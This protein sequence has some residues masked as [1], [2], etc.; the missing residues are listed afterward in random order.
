VAA[1]TL[2]L[3]SIPTDWI[4]LNFKT[5]ESEYKIVPV[6]APLP[7]K[8]YHMSYPIKISVIKIWFPQFITL[9]DAFLTYVW[10]LTAL[11]ISH[12]NADHERWKIKTLLYILKIT[13]H[14]KLE[15]HSL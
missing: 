13:H 9:Y 15:D 4:V 6:S 8:K 11:M 12:S 10:V 7:H 14:N 1:C 5:G 3:F 2:L